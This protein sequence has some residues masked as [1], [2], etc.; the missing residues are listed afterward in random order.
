MAATLPGLLKA[1]QAGSAPDVKRVLSYNPSLAH[2]RS[3][4]GRTPLHFAADTT[5]LS[6][7][8]ELLQT[9]ASCHEADANLEVPLHI[10]CRQV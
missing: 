2:A 10:A 4:G 6:I 7:V 3:A 1:I 9:G 5:H 8:K